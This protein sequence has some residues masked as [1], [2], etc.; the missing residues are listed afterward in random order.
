MSGVARRCP[1]LVGAKSMSGAA[2]I[3]VE[4]EGDSLSLLGAKEPGFG[5]S[6][7]WRR[8]I[9]AVTEWAPPEL[10]RS[11]RLR[12]GANRREATLQLPARGR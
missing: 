11:R 10:V 9:R 5:N 7:C 12:P 4:T 3:C 2:Y 6:C 8:S 1:S